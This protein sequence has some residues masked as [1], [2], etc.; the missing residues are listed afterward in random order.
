MIPVVF[1]VGILIAILAATRK[2]QAQEAAASSPA[3]KASSP[4][5][6]ASVKKIVDSGDPRKMVAA[7]QVAK[8]GGD[9][10]LADGLVKEARNAAVVNA[11]SYPSPFPTVAGPEWTQFVIYLRGKNPKQITPG[12][13]LGLFGFGMRRL[14]D[15]GLASNPHKGT[16]NGKTVWLADW[17]PALTPGPDTFLGDAQTQYNAFVKS[18]QLYAAQVHKEIPEAVGAQLDGK[19]V[20]LSGLLAVAHRAGWAGLK[21]WMGDAK[22]RAAH[23]QSTDIFNKENGLF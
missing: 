14:V 20:T 15:L 7:A 1:G 19:A 4:S 22:V 3:V 18:M 8:Q 21:E 11:K 13:S 2:A 17:A 12:Y 9:H 23:P 6:A 10:A 5:T 16:Y